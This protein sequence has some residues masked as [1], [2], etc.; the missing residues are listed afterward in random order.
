MKGGAT[1][2]KLTSDYKGNCVTM[3]SELGYRT[4]S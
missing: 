1:E 3:T 4:T 2:L